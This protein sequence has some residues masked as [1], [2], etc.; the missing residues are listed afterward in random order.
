MVTQ[1][2][3]RKRTSKKASPRR[4]NAAKPTDKQVREWA[5][6]SGMEGVQ[7]RGRVSKH[8]VEAYAK[9]D[10]KVVEGQART[11]PVESQAK[12]PTLGVGSVLAKANANGRPS[13]YIVTGPT[14]DRQI[15]KSD[16]VYV[17]EIMLDDTS[18]E[19]AAESLSRLVSLPPSLERATLVRSL[20]K[21]L[22]DL[23][24]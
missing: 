22:A 5:V 15:L 3:P 11:M 20:T 21:R 2:P 1:A 12:V 23:A 8:L 18:L 9:A 7:M 14:G 24:S 10:G 17:E 16:S 4:R 6:A 19:K 13:V